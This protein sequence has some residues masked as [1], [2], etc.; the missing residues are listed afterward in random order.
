M[1]GFPMKKSI[2]LSV[3][4][5]LFLAVTITAQTLPPTNLTYRISGK[6]RGRAFQTWR[7][8]ENMVTVNLT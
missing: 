1:A 7:F 2:L 4:L 5:E 8:G 3:W 6:G